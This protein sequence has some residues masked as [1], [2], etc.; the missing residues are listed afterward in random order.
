MA[1]TTGTM[2]F[3]GTQTGQTYTVDCQVPDA[4]ATRWTFNASGLAVSTSDD[5]WKAPEE[6]VLVDISMPGVPTAVGGILLF[7]GAI[8]SGRTFRWTNHD[9]GLNDRISYKIR[10]PAGEQV[11][12]LQY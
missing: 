12:I 11:G 9:D 10:I 5:Y 3:I 4:V 7:S 2:V 6:C 8:Q 1:A